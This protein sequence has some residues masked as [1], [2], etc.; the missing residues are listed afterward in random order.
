MPIKPNSDIELFV[1]DWVPEMAR[2]Y[3]RDLRPRWAMEEAGIAYRTTAVSVGAKG[4]YLSLQPFGQVP[5]MKEGELRIFETGAM[6]LHLGRKSEILMPTDAQGCAS[7]ESWLFAAL[8]SVEPHAFE[9]FFVHVMEADQEWAKL[10][11]PSLHDMV[12]RRL[13]PLADALGQKDYFVGPFTV[14]DIAMATVLR[15]INGHIPL[16]EFPVLDAY[17]KRCLARPA[18]KRALDAQYADFTGEAPAQFATA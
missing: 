7:T 15:E 12:K 3:V 11:R 8:N 14:A 2:G 17:L 4:D 1:F 13:A 6:L 5:A 10:R 18:F 9:L 16:T